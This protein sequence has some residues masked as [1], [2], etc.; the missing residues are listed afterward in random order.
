MQSAL[1]YAGDSFDVSVYGLEERAW[2]KEA[3][4]GS[5]W[6][7]PNLFESHNNLAWA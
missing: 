6:K 4:P 2:I 7:A 1:M 5:I 3:S